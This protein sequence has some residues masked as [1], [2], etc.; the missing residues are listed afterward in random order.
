MTEMNGAQLLKQ[1]FAQI[2]MRRVGVVLDA[3]CDAGE[4]FKVRRIPG[5][6]TG[7]EGQACDGKVWGNA[8]PTIQW[9]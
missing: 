3:G 2:A 9:L 5:N 1:E 8:M 6:R 7:R 4:A